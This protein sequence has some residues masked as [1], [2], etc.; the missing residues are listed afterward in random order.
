MSRAEIVNAVVAK[1]EAPAGAEPALDASTAPPGGASGAGSAPADEE[2][3]SGAQPP[4]GALASPG[5]PI[6]H[7]ILKAKLQ[8]D[9]HRRQA[10]ALRKQHAQETEAA[11]KAREEA[12]AEAAKWRGIGK[13]KTWLESIKEAGHDPRK[14]FEEMQA[15]ARRAGTPEAQLEAMGKAFEAKLAAALDEHVNPL[16]KTIEEITAERDAL[17][18]QTAEQGFVGELE[19]GLALEHFRSLTDEYDTPVL[20]NYAKTFRDNEDRFWSAVKAYKV[21]LTR[22]DG[23]Y[24]MV[25]ILNVLKTVQTAHNHR[26]QQRRNQSAAPH[27]SQA[28]QQQPPQAKP[29]VN[30]TV[31][32]NADPSTIGN[33]LAA[34]T[35][36]EADKLKGMTRQQRVAYLSRKYG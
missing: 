19:R 23:S 18:K 1:H 14:A 16:K 5:A 28:G 31:E 9:R 12:E 34:S 10:K 36:T 15:E 29:P 30:G 8:A 7:D 2:A 11:K 25:D 6:D 24:T 22:D 33:D 20:L 4:G 17:R 26:M 13:G 3:P 27:T 35:A 21:P 32:R